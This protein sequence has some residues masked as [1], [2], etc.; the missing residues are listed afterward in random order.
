MADKKKNVKK[1]D[2]KTVEKPIVKAAVKQPKKVMVSEDALPAIE[3]AKVYNISSF[4]FFTL[5]K[6]L[7][8]SDDTLL[9]MSK[10]REEYQ[11][12]IRR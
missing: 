10:F 6:K 7:G 5:K 3:I 2:E 8:I 12:I 1:T 9:T 11:K 4:D